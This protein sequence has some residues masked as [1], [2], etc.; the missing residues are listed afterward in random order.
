MNTQSLRQFIFM[1]DST[2]MNIT[3]LCFCAFGGI[4]SFAMM[5]ICILRFAGGFYAAGSA[6]FLAALMS[7]S[8][9]AYSM[10]CIRRGDLQPLSKIAYPL[11]AGMFIYGFTALFFIDGGT[12]GGVPVFFILAVAAT[13]F[14]LRVRDAVVMICLEVAAYVMNAV[15][16]GLYPESVNPELAGRSTCSFRW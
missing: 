1:P 16:A 7:A 9:L 3:A 11:T 2:G 8:V 10:R 15:F 13:P 5:I 14:F 6:Y 4:I 12:L